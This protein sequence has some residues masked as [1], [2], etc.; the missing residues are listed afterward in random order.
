M[1]IPFNPLTYRYHHI[2]PFLAQPLFWVFFFLAPLLHWFRVDMIH[3]K[4]VFMNQPYPFEFKYLMWLPIVFYAGVI[5]IGVVS[6]VWGRLFCG[7]ACPHNTLTEWTRPFRAVFNRDHLPLSIARLYQKLPILKTL[8]S[9]FSIPIAFMLTFGLSVLLSFYIVPP[10]WVLAQYVSFKPHVALVFGHMLFT[11]IGL[12][13]LYA[14]H[15][16]CRTC[17][18]YGMCQSLSAYQEGKKWRPMEIAFN[19]PNT[20]ETDCKT[21]TACQTVCPVDIDP[22][23]PLALGLK[24]G[25]FYGCFNCGECIDACKTVQFHQDRK[26]FLTFEQPWQLVK[27]T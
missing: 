3:Q 1:R 15:D 20:M 7:W 22:R 8:F 12:F 13:L 25:Q 21:C 11:L 5:A 23:K 26:G 17:C 2:R 27:N 24:V 19:S 4:L 16:F 14:G 6:F 9:L 18:P 10:A